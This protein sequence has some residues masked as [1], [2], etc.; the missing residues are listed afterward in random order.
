LKKTCFKQEETKWRKKRRVAPGRKKKNENGRW[1]SCPRSHP[2]GGKR[3][4]KPVGIL[5][6]VG[7]PTVVGSDS[8]SGG[9]KRR[10]L[11]KT[12]GDQRQV[13]AIP[14]KRIRRRKTA[15]GMVREDQQKR[16]VQE[17]RVK[18]WHGFESQA[19]NDWVTLVKKNRRKCI[20]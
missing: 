4:I 15:T 9:M 11:A 6:P 8:T 16:D 3:E 1:C 14:R 20:L 2:Q 17:Q 19:M 18:F 10:R 7:E 13:A 12:E 5:S